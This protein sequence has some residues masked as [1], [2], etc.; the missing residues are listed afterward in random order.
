[1]RAEMDSA[2]IEICDLSRQFGATPA[3]KNVTLTVPRGVVFGLVG[4]NG[5]GKTTL[6]KHMMGLLKPQRGSVS[7]FGSNPVTNPT[8]VLSRVGY[9]SELNELPEWMSVHE[10]VRFTRA[11]YPAW[12]ESYAESLRRTFELDDT[13]LVQQLSKGQRARLGLLLALAH[14]ADLLILDEPSSGLDPLVRRD[15]LRAIIKTISDEGRTVVFS[16]HLLDEVERVADQV[17][18]IESG[19]I[20]QNE[21]L[22]SLKASYHRLFLRFGAAPEKPPQI[23][24]FFNWQGGDNN[25]S[26]FYRGESADLDRI[27][28]RFNAHVLER[29]APSL[30]EIFMA[31]IESN[32]LTQAERQ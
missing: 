8:A 31:L 27:M 25:W 3:L 12:D 26:V 2:V 5:A 6:I 11:F 23:D 14:R 24:G 17:A 1:M 7:V 30:Q 10:L 9:L 16:S 4:T 15:I 21:T 29:A 28:A 20:I 13:R 22:E 19:R 18:I 32:H